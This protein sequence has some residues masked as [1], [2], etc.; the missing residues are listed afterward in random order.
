MA[1]AHIDAVRVRGNG[2]GS[3]GKTEMFLIHRLLNQR[4]ADN[5]CRKNPVTTAAQLKERELGTEA[6]NRAGIQPFTAGS[7]QA[8]GSPLLRI[9]NKIIRLFN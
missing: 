9:Q 1:F 4:D 2:K 7:N 3:C 5:T 6:I 8:Y